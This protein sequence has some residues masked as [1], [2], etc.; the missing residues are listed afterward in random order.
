MYYYG[1]AYYG[2]YPAYYYPARYYYRP[3]T[4]GLVVYL[5]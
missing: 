1:P 5:P 3:F 4:P 2:Y